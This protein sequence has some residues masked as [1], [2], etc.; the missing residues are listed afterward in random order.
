MTIN[1]LENIIIKVIEIISEKI[2]IDKID[3]NKDSKLKDLGVDNLD[4]FEILLELEDKFEILIK[5]EDFEEV[6]I[7][8]DIASLVSRLN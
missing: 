2:G 5:D 6:E 7:V 8:K 1:N 3:I 4:R